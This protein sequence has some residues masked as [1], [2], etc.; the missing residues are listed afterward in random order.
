M[1]NNWASFNGRGEWL[2]G[3]PVNAVITEIREETPTVRTFFFDCDFSPHPGQYMMVWVR[4]V[5]EI[6]MSFSYSSGI[7]V[8]SVGRATEA[9]FSLGPGDSVGLRGPLGV[10]FSLMDGHLQSQTHGHTSQI[11]GRILLIGGGVG[12][13]PLA[14][15]GEYARERGVKVTSLM[16]FR[17]RDDVIFRERFEEV[18][19]LIITT[20]DGSLGIPGRASAGLDRLD[21]GDFDQIYLCGPELMML[22]V[23]RRC[24]DFLEKIQASISRY[25]KCGI[26]VCGSCSLDPTGLRVCVEGPVLRADLLAKSEL[27]RYRRGA[28][29]EKEEL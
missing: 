13:A 19:D 3:R 21:P 17:C 1:K 5:D 16:G 15:L 18:G 9:L 20:D 29:G 22:D 2:R 8:Q 4:G 6:P 27:G 14:L 26:G 10:G 24:Q 7:T 23:I 25:I 12:A 11:Q 28:S